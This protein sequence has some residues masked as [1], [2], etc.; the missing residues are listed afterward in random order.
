MKKIPLNI[1]VNVK[2]PDQIVLMADGVVLVNSFIMDA[3]TTRGLIRTLEAALHESETLLV[4]P[5]AAHA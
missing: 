1:V 3:E 5:N 2:G 4:R